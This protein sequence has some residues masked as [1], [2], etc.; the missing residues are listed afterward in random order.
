VERMFG[1]RCH[2]N[3]RKAV[4]EQ[5]GC[6]SGWEPFG[7]WSLRKAQGKSRLETERLNDGVDL[8]ESGSLRKA[9][10]KARLETERLND[11]VDLLESGSESWSSDDEKNALSICNNG[12]CTWKV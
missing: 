5:H 4:I 7:Q 2:L 8:L 10:E 9:Q 11:G 6:R 1:C 12:Q 3:L